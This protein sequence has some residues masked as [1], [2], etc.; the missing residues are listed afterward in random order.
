VIASRSVILL[1]VLVAAATVGLTGVGL[2]HAS[3]SPTYSREIVRIFQQ[4]CQEC[5]RTDGRTIDEMG[6]AAIIFTYDDEKP[7]VASR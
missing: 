5:D 6:H 1:S 7:P 4:H 2:S 3:E